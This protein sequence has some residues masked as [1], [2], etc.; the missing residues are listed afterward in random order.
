MDSL[1]SVLIYV[2]VLDKGGGPLEALIYTGSLDLIRHKEIHES[3]ARLPDKLEDIH[4]ND[5]TSRQFVYHEFIPYLATYG[6]PEFN[7]PPMQFFC[8]NDNPTSTT[9]RN[10]I[11]DGP[12]KALLRHRYISYAAISMD[13][14]ATAVEV[15]KLL[16]LIK[17]YLEQ[18][19]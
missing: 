18:F 10:I 15:Q 3:L 8:S 4:T 13:H 16:E 19:E 17:E 14:Q 9:Y 1:F 2:N 12:F 11:E 7:C 5:L 6:I